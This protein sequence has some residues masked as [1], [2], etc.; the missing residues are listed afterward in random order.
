MRV[1]ADGLGFLVRNADLAVEGL[2]ALL[3]A[4]TVGGAITA[5][6]AAMLGNAGAIVGFR[7]MAQVSVAAA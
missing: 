6:N 5:M 1:A 4:R 2:T 3:I 7:L